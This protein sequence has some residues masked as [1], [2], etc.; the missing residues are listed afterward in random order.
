MA[1]NTVT[2]YQNANALQNMAEQATVETNKI[3]EDTA[4]PKEEP[5]NAPTISTAARLTKTVSFFV[6]LV[7][8]ILGVIYILGYFTGEEIFPLKKVV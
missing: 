3:Q 5:T 4:M 8:A 7:I 6:P 2:A 1:T